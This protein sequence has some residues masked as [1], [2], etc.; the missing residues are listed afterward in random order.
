MTCTLHSHVLFFDT[1][2]SK[3]KLI[4]LTRTRIRV[5]RLS[6][7]H[8]RP[9][10]T[11][12]EDRIHSHTSGSGSGSIEVKMETKLSVQEK[13]LR[14][15][16]ATAD[17]KWSS[18]QTQ[19]YR[20]TP[21]PRFSHCPPTPT[22]NTDFTNTP[23]SRHWKIRPSLSL[24]SLSILHM[25]CHTLEYMMQSPIAEIKHFNRK[26]SSSGNLVYFCAILYI[27]KNVL[28]YSSF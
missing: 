16:T 2:C 10:A 14:W 5:V 1:L 25:S 3:L 19:Q 21:A 23:T 6:W 22:Q 4:N 20:T 11:Y 24:S 18:A 9:H 15:E 28:F 12:T 7:Q 13:K 8:Q 26:N 17:Q 27:I